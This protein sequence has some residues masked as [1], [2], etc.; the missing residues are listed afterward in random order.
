MATATKEVIIPVTTPTATPN[1]PKNFRYPHSFASMFSAQETLSTWRKQPNWQIPTGYADYSTV[2]P[3]ADGR[4]YIDVNISP[5]L[6][7]NNGCNSY[8]MAATG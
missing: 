5:S 7:G 4:F 2:S 8:L 1:I 6:H 3:G